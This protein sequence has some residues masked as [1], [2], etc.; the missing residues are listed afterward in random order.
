MIYH[1]NTN[2]QSKACTYVNLNLVFLLKTV[3]GCTGTLQSSV[4]TVVVAKNAPIPPFPIQ[5]E[6]WKF[7]WYRFWYGYRFWYWYQAYSVII[8]PFHCVILKTEACVFLATTKPNNLITQTPKQSAVY[9]LCTYVLIPIL[10]DTI[11]IQH[12][13]RYWY[14]SNT[15][16]GTSYF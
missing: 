4:L 16:K 2:T 6:N 14:W 8:H 1:G 13:Y 11:G 12:W 15:H 3:F 7:Y 10:S 9:L 5:Q